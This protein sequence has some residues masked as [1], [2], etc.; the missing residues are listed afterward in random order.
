MPCETSWKALAGRSRTPL[1][2][3]AF[4]AKT[5]RDTDVADW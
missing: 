4:I 1:A 2:A 3:P 5:P